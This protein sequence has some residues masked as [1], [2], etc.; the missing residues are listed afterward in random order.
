MWYI[1]YIYKTKGY[2]Y[3]LTNAGASSG[4]SG[5]SGEPEQTAKG[6]IYVFEH[7]TWNFGI[8]TYQ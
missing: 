6:A 3:K 4:P 1:G 5:T 2:N 7:K 8:S